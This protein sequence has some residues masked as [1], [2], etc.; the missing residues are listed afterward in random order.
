MKFTKYGTIAKVN[1]KNLYMQMARLRD[2]GG[3][4]DDGKHGW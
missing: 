4:R 2:L 3:C 1:V